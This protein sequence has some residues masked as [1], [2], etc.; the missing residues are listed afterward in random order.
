MPNC[1]VFK[2]HLNTGQPNHWIKKPHWNTIQLD[3][4]LF[5]YMLVQYSNGLLSTQDIALKANHLKSKLKKAG[6][7]VFPSVKWSIFRSPLYFFLIQA[8]MDR[9][10]KKSEIGGKRKET[11]L[12]KLHNVKRLLT[13]KPITKYTFFFNIKDFLHLFEGGGRGRLWVVK[14]FQI[15]EVCSNHLNTG[16]QNTR[17]I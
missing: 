16:H 8:S 11:K 17:F 7:Q 6:I 5:S 14:S 9:S 4:I 2:C 1:P 12:Q 3:A 15:V 13:A 10:Q